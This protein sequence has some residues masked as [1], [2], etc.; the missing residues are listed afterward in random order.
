MERALARVI[1]ALN[2]ALFAAE[3]VTQPAEDLTIDRR[4]W[5]LDRSGLVAPD[6]ERSRK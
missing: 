5:P 6:V 2:E 1:D 4:G 3:H